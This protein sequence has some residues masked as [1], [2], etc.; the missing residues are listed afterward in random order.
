MV[1]VI[2][3]FAGSRE[4]TPKAVVPLRE[5]PAGFGEGIGERMVARLRA[6]RGDFTPR[7]WMI[8]HLFIHRYPHR[9]G[10][11]HPG[12]RVRLVR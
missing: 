9:L 7:D 6:N 8:A 11:S 5:D 3:G 4:T 2:T 1:S 12:N 10:D